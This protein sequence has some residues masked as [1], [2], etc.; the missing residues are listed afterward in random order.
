M[1]TVAA[2]QGPCIEGNVD[3]NID[4][5]IN[6]M[7]TAQE[8]QVDIL[9]MPECFL[10][11]YLDTLV[12]A[13]QT[14][15]SLDSAEFHQLLER[16]SEYSDTT[17]IFGLNEQ[18]DGNIYNTAVVIESGRLIGKYQKAYTYAPY[19]YY[20][21]GRDFPVFEKKG[22]K[23]GIIICYDIMF[24]EPALLTAMAGAQIIFCPMFNRVSIESPM[25][26]HL[27]NKNHFIA[28]AFDTNCWLICSDVTIDT[29]THTCPGSACILDG[30]GT[31]HRLSSPYE[32]TLLIHRID[33]E[34]L[35]K[36]KKRRFYGHLELATQLGKLM[37]ES[38][39]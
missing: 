35:S 22:I 32:T 11:G 39:N 26:D 20:V 8:H 7:R 29:A 6:N 15:W 4:T 14:A 3:K 12:D 36:N 18:N 25:A 21:L 17:L 28:R 16:L 23:F 31:I 33:L 19:D 30:N 27:A 9:V 2:F 5:I 10:Q 13:T 37:I 1:L 34:P 38:K 24:R